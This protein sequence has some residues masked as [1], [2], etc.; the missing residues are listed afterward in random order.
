MSTLIIAEA[1]VNHN[2]DIN[3]AKELISAAKDCGADIVKFQTWITEELLN[4]NA[5][6]AAYQKLN[7]KSLSQYEMLK[8]LELSFNDFREL[9]KY[10]S[11]VGIRFLSTPDE[12]L[13]LN[14]LVDDLQMDI[15]KVGSG[16]VTNIPYLQRVG[17]KGKKV[18]L[19]TGMVGLAEVERAYYTLL[20]HGAPSVALLHCT[21]AYPAPHNSVNLKAML[22]LKEA[23]K[24]EVGYSD[25][26]Q[27]S[28]VAIAAVAL[29]AAIIEKHFT[30]DNK[31][32]GP[33]HA[34]SATPNEF[35]MLVQQI[36]NVELA[37]SGN[38]IKRI[39]AIEQDTKKVVTKGIYASRN[40]DSGE[41]IKLSDLKFLRPP[42]TGIN[43]DQFELIIGR[44]VT[45]PLEKGEVV[46]YSDIKF[47]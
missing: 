17:A 26:T 5:P 42:H 8:R 6:M 9:N 46:K 43:A 15:V 39:Q 1:G 28:E 19:S 25:H 16:E 7:D 21:S 30:L 23:F 13:S 37:T 41:I 4:I 35:K 20:N 29:G 47:L 12:E 34:A 18:I 24:T 3:L 2:G 31:M 22:T 44:E 36:R 33:D 45:T 10:A 27:G 11:K 38:G 14:F 32:E 40:L